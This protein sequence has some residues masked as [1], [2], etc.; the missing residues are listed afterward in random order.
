MH[1][2]CKCGGDMYLQDV[3]VSRTTNPE[4]EDRFEQR[5]VCSE[6]ETNIDPNNDEL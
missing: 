1:K 2:K 6:C 3:L 4:E 5:Y